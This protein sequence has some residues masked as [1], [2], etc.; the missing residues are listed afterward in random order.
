MKSF[1]LRFCSEMIDAIRNFY[2]TCAERIILKQKHTLI[3]ILKAFKLFLCNKLN[4]S[5]EIPGSKYE[6]TSRKRTGGTE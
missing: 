5:H 1:L 3:S 2:S 4:P 6:R